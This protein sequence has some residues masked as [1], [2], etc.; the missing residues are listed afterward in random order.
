MLSQRISNRTQAQEFN[1]Y[2]THGR[3]SMIA[4]KVCTW[5]LI[6]TLVLPLWPLSARPLL[7]QAAN[8]N[9]SRNVQIAPMIVVFLLAVC[10]RDDLPPNT[11]CG[12]IATI[13]QT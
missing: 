6:L 4:R 8:S 7:V 9:Y 3:I 10:R 12:R 2:S 13:K 1:N 11:I 5:F